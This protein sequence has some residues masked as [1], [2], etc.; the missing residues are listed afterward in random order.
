MTGRRVYIQP[1]P[2]DDALA[3]WRGRLE[4]AGIWAPLVGEA[5]RV[6]DAIGRV[7]AE[8]VFA[9]LSSPFYHSAAMDG[10]AVRFADTFGA[11]E[12]SPKCLAIGEQAVYVDTGDPL[13]D[14]F[15]SVIMVEDIDELEKGNI[16][17]IAPATPWQHV[18]VIGEDIVAT[19]LVAPENHLLRPVDV[20]S[21]LA[22]GITELQ[23][24][25]RPSIAVLPTGNELVQPG[26][27]LK[28]GDIIEYNSHMLAGM[29]REWGADTVRYGIVPDNKELLKKYIKEAAGTHDMVVVNAGSSAGSEDFT[30]SAIEELGEVVLHG[31]NTKPGK[32]VILGLVDGRPVIGVPGYPVSAYIAFKLFGRG[33]LYAWQGREAPAAETMEA[34]LSRQMASPLG[35]EEFVRVKLGRVGGSVVATPL[36]RGAGVLMSLVRA[37]GIIRIPPSVEG[38]A[39]GSV[40]EAEL[41]R[42]REDV[43]NTVVCIGSHDNALDL[44]ANF[45]KKSHPAL[46]LSSA[47]VGSL[48]GIMALKRDEAHVAGSHL[49]DEATGEYNVGYIKKHLPGQPVVLVNLVYRTQGLLVPGGNPKGIKGFGDIARPDVVF[50]NRQAG[51]GTRILTD[52]SLAKAG[53]DPASV[54]GYGHEEYTHM[55][56]ASAVLSGVADTGLGILAAANALGLDFIPVAEER[57]DLVIPVRYYET[58]M[59]SAVLEIIRGDTGYRQAV[60][61]MGGYDT[62]DMGK[63]IWRS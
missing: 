49:I 55:G 1:T 22:G 7:T 59:V 6:E 45:L 4:A 30:Y 54:Q 15:D 44:L 28:K 40:V 56:V 8:A 20:S 2:L 53:I 27:I 5:V 58:Q 11:S 19:E 13:P 34:K 41:L 14:G 61:A 12:R 25:R 10:V 24:R 62:R 35:T 9:R 21:L 52:L 43:E 60:E 37:D 47:H 42:P 50:V 23:V 18:R 48:G 39:A 26:A 36:Q 31:V 63:V 29:A 32:P 3:I 16:E 33:L 17:I 51:A 38:I 57:Y 46:S